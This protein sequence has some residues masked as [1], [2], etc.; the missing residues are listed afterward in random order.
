MDSPSETHPQGAL[1]ARIELFTPMMGNIVAGGIFSFL[2]LGGGLALTGFILREVYRAGGNLPVE[3]KQG[4]SWIAVGLGSALGVGFVVG[5]VL[6]A[7][8]V[9]WLLSHRVEFC[10]NGFRYHE[11][12]ATEE[13]TWVSVASIRERILYERP[14]ILKGPVKLLLPK[15]ASSSYVV[16]TTNAKEYSFDGNS[17]RRIKR[18]GELLR[19][20]AGQAGVP[21][22]TVE[23]H[24]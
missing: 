3:A 23:E 20:R 4:M 19:E 18:F 8:Y 12:R 1:G 22:E 6:L 15:M 14:P 5:G 11:G 13:V 16:V 9:R 7:R 10:E 24:A 2:L 21:W 17:I